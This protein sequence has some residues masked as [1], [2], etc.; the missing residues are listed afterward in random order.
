MDSLSCLRSVIMARGGRAYRLGQGKSWVRCG[1]LFRAAGW[2]HLQL[3]TSRQ[4]NIFSQNN[5]TMSIHSL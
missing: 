3:A 4:T 2:Q 1:I 5:P